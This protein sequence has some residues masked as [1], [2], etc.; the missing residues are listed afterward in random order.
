MSHI[1]L[2][3]ASR[4]WVVLAALVVLAAA[5]AFL[6]QRPSPAS[7]ESSYEAAARAQYPPSRVPRWMAALYATPARR[8]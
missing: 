6:L 5:A 1:P 2:R 3:I 4:P 7:A 8:P